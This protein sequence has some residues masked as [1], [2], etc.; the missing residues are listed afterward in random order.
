MP[1]V[2]PLTIVLVVVDVIFLVVGA[3]YLVRTSAHLPAFFPGHDAFARQ[4]ADSTHRH[5]ALALAAFVAGTAA[6][7]AVP[8]TTNPEAA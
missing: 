2:R 5:I 4:D 7:V 3:I 8:F 1:E 6:L